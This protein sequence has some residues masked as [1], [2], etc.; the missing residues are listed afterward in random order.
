MIESECRPTRRAFIDDRCELFGKA[1]VLRYVDA[2]Q[3]GPVWDTI[4]DRDRIEL[5]WVRP[6]RGLARLLDGDP[7]WTVLHRDAVSILFR[8]KGG[9]NPASG[10]VAR[11]TD[12]SDPATKSRQFE[13]PH[14]PRRSISRGTCDVAGHDRRPVL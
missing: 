3:G 10:S 7:D 2:L 5:V 13:T 12:L 11:I 14:H 1:E 8:R 4:R 9:L 6:N